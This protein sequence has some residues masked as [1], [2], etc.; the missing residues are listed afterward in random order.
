MKKQCTTKCL[1]TCGHW[2]MFAEAPPEIG[3]FLMCAVCG[4]E[5]NVVESEKS[6]R[7]LPEGKDLPAN[8]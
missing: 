7:V 2:M 6:V 3:D 8:Y 1:Y 4:R 5:V